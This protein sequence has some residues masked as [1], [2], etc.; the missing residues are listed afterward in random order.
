MQIGIITRTESASTRKIKKKRIRSV[1]QVPVWSSAPFINVIS[2][3]LFLCL[4]YELVTHGQ[5][6][7][8]MRKKINSTKWRNFKTIF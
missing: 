4:S 1:K 6:R 5:Y 8:L 7:R 3:S 2:R